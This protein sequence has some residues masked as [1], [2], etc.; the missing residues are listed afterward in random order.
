MKRPEVKK[1][2][3][4]MLGFFAHFSACIPLHASIAKCLT[5]LTSK[6]CQN[7]VNRSHEHENAFVTLKQSLSGAA[8]IPL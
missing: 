1:E 2:I 3:R 4:Q 6:R 7:R 8:I 5:D